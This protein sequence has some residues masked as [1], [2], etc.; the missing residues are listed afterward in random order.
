MKSGYCNMQARRATLEDI[1]TLIGLGKE[2]IEE[3]PVYNQM[4]PDYQKQYRVFLGFILNPEALVLILEDGSG[5]FVGHVEDT[6]WFTETYAWEDLLFVQKDKRRSNRG[7]VLMKGFEDW[8]K[9]KQTAEIRIGFTTEVD[10]TNTI[11]LFEQLG[12]STCGAFFRK[13][14]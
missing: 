11:T 5:F 12:Y 7:V 14:V 9:E 8:A 6:L 1:G 13:V 10:V 2:M 3:S 4:T